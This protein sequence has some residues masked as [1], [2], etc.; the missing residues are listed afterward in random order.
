MTRG[1][2]A[3]PV[4]LLG[5]GGSGTRLLA[6]LALANGV[7][8][9]SDLNVSS[10][11]EEWV[12]TIYSLAIESL[13]P[14]IASHSE[15]DAYWRSRLH[16]RAAAITA[17]PALPVGASW[18]WKLP[19]TMLAIA[20]VLRTFPAAKIVHLVRHPLTSSLRR[21]HLTSRNDNIIG[22]SVLRA[23]YRAFGRDRAT[24]AD[25]PEYVRNAVTWAF[26]VGCVLDVLDEFA[27]GRDRALLLRYE[28]LCADPARSSTA[29]AAFLGRSDAGDTTTLAAS[30]D[31]MR[32]G[33][34]AADERADLVWRICGPTAARIGYTRTS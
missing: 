31:G 8:L 15:R 21:T 24:I 16:E 27:I 9:G 34:V 32:T 26:Q 10:D 13:E 20:Q 1:A 33:S 17:R 5:R 11:S 6:Q 28:D 14:G 3:D 29:L 2:V 23:A 22:R 19:E 4:V 18:G 7:F 12:E 30:I 25:D